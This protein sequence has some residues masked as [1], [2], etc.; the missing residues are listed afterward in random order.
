MTNPTLSLTVSGARGAGKTVL[1]RKVAQFLREQGY[2]VDTQRL[3]RGT[4]YA[5]DGVKGDGRTITLFEGGL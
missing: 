1:I 5:F 4:D 3:P 2:A